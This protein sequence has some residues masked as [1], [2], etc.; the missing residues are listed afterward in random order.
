[1]RRAA[2]QIEDE[3]GFAVI[4]DS[5]TTDEETTGTAAHEDEASTTA[6]DNPLVSNYVKKLFHDLI[7]W[8]SEHHVLYF[9]SK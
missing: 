6:V 2:D 9:Y 8:R 3:A 5:S 1:M 7:E 4:T